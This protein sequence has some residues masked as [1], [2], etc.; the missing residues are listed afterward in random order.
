[1]Q[2]YRSHAPRLAI[3][4]AVGMFLL[5]GDGRLVAAQDRG[6]TAASESQK[7]LDRALDDERHAIAFYEAVMAR[8]GERPPFARIVHTERR[9]AEMLLEQYT[10]L[11]L[12][13]PPDRW[14]S[15]AFRL[16]DTFAEVCDAAEISEVLNAGLYDE[17]IAQVSDA[18]V[19]QMFERLRAASR[20]RHARAFRRHSNGWRIVNAAELSAA[21]KAQ[22]TLATHARDEVFKQLMARLSKEL[23]ADGPARAIG[24]CKQVAP[25]IARDVGQ[26]R[27][28]RIGRTS[29]KLRNPQ[30]AGPPWTKLLLHDKPDTPRL[31]AGRDGRLGVTLP[32]RVATPCLTC[33]GPE[34]S[35]DPAVRKQLRANYPD[36]QAV[37]FRV[38]D[39]RGWFWVEVPRPQSG[40]RDADGRAD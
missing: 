18:T 5:M 34:A 4:L 10:R 29:W 33:H 40:E 31:A 6:S 39:L 26:R 28:V 2:N 36:D 30:N 37:G 21:Q 8:F 11:G 38:G 3:G 17:L 14:R 35:I 32:I 19:R 27:N 25:E 15:H 22:Q 12:E 16:P 20:E 23:A 13:P 7:T 1:M 9:H 24:V